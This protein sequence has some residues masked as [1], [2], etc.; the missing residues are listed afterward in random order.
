MSRFSVP[1]IKISGIA[2]CVPKDKESNTDYDW[3]TEKE[4]NL[5]IKTTGI[6]E[7]RIARK[8]TTTSD[9]CYAATEKLLRELNWNKEEIGILIFVSQSRDYFLPAT[10]IILQDRLQLTPTTIAFD[11]SLGC[12]GYVYG[13][14]VISSLMQT[15]QTKKALLMAGDISSTSLNKRDKSTYPLFG[16]AGTVTALELTT[17]NQHM[18]FDLKSDGSGYEAII[19]PDGGLRNPIT[20]DSFVEREIEK[21]IWR[22][23]RDLKLDGLAVFNFSITKVHPQIEHL[24]S[25]SGKE[26]TDI[27]YFVFH[28][29]NKL[30]LETIRKK[31]KIEPE[32][33]PY[34]L[35]K[36]GNTSSAS[37]PLTIV[38]ELKN[39]VETQKLSMLF[40]GFGVGLSWGTV[41]LELDKIKCPEIIEFS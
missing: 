28:Q 21:G 41:I 5:L 33:V 38:T 16:D 20:P 32:Q 24:L 37:I 10:A 17:E 4:Q 31:L 6:E 9:L 30:I 22:C 35:L 1:N 15:T 25:E 13:L 2:A 14:S 23:N 34:S 11:I 19:I 8:G 7:R 36:Y 27:N 39:E 29:A 18:D 40:C 12:S 3:I 26:T